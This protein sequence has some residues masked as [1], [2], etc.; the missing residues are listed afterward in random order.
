M[1]LEK[2]KAELAKLL[3][4]FSAIKTDKAVLE[5][6]G[7]ELV[8]GETV[9]VTNE[10]D[11]RVAPEDGEYKTEDGKIITVEG[12][13]VTNILEVETE[14]DAEETVDEPEVKEDVV[15]EP[16]VEAA[17]EEPATEDEPKESTEE[18]IAN[19]RKEVDE[20]YKLVDALL[21]KIGESRKEADERFTKL[22]TLSAAKPASE[23][24][25]AIS[26]SPK[27]GISKLDKFLKNYAN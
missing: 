27:T 21:D 7:D 16:T 11:E 17:E 13:R 9:Y 2:I 18:A 26:E 10:E 24:F 12:G 5:Y 25:E 4:K 8:V 20:L 14:V 22:E 19:L 6:A 15:E 1:K 3:I 23:E